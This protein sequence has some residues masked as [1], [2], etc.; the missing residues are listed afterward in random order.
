MRHIRPVLATSFAA[1]LVACAPD[2]PGAGTPA[3][4][5]AAGVS[6]QAATAPELDVEVVAD[7]LTLPWDVGLLPDGTALVGER[8]GRLVAIPQDGPPREVA[9]DL[10]GFF[11]G[12]EAGLM[13]LAVE[14]EGSLLACYATE[15]AGRPRDVRVARVA[16][17]EDLTSAAVEEVLVEGMPITSGR[18]SGCRLLL[19]DGTLYVGTGDAAD[20]STPQA[21]DSLGGKVLAVNLA[22][23][24]LPDAPF[25]E[26]ADPR[27][28][29]YG[30][31]NVQGL[32]ARP[33]TEQVWSAEHGP[34]VDDEVN[35][36]VPGGNYGW[37]PGPGYDERVPMTD[38]DTFP[39]AVEAVWS[40][41][42]PTR[43]LAGAVFLQG[44]AWG[45]WEGALA[46]AELKGSGITVLM[47]EGDAVVG[48]TRIAEL[49]GDHGRLRSLTLADD[50]ALWVTTS[51]GEDDQLLR[52]TPRP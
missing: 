42:R 10:P 18:H 37:D 32:A 48:E 34:D 23:E 39:D 43:A 4:D 16:L 9:L 49:D 36:V 38:L 13:G 29:T 51:N 27:V 12:S 14:D 35:L 11:T 19:V 40:T 15:S 30:H 45:G 41:G 6:D 31:R 26:G 47:L 25:V 20:E 17:V 28:F 50:G 22:G 46:V 52:V 1:L 21:L 24:P 33:G 44:S 3:P 2:A 5:P 8:G 7:R